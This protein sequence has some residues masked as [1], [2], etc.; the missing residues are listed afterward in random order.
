MLF[1]SRAHENRWSA[2]RHQKTRILL[3]TVGPSRRSREG[4]LARR[5][6]CAHGRS[7]QLDGGT[8]LIVPRPHWALKQVGIPL[9]ASIDNGVV[10]HCS[11]TGAGS[12]LEVKSSSCSWLLTSVGAKGS[13]SAAVVRVRGQVD[14]GGNSVDRLDAGVRHKSFSARARIARARGVETYV[15]PRVESHLRVHAFPT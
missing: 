9:R 1:R 2:F 12:A 3:A 8:R 4:G 14:A 11:A 5:A 10:S 7:A 15:Y 13:N 6:N